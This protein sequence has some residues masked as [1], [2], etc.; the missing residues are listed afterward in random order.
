[1]KRISRVLMACLFVL[2]LIAVLNLLLYINDMYIISVSRQKKANHYHN[3]QIYL[4][5]THFSEDE[6]VSEDDYLAWKSKKMK[7][8]S[9]MESKYT[10]S[11]RHP[12]EPLQ[13]DPPRPPF[14]TGESKRLGSLQE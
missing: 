6:G 14:P 8:L 4:K 3:S 2:S 11:A 9:Q 13:P 12:W 5:H 10:D 1:M 7:W